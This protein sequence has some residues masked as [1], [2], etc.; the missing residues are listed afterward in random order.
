MPS[1]AMNRSKPNSLSAHR[2]VLSNDGV[3]ELGRADEGMSEL[4]PGTI[5]N[6]G[7]TTVPSGFGTAI[8]ISGASGPSS[9][10][11]TEEP[12]TGHACCRLG[13]QWSLGI[14]RSAL[15]SRQ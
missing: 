8:G 2:Q 6:D 12:Q 9:E 5:R 15:Q 7:R 13:G 11:T 4:S 14:L 10:S 3:N 1:T